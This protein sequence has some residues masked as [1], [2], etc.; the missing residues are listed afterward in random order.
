MKPRYL[1]IALVLI[2][3][4]AGGFWLKA[5]LTIDSCLDL[6]GRWNYENAVCEPSATKK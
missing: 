5:Q 3:F 2:L 6:G 1:W 4:V